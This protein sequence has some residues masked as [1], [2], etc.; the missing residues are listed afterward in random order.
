MK[1]T[2]NEVAVMFTWLQA[3]INEVGGAENLALPEMEVASKIIMS[4]DEVYQLFKEIEMNQS[5]KKLFDCVDRLPD[6]VKDSILNW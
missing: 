4:N 5:M 2:T 1:L 3:R 6:K